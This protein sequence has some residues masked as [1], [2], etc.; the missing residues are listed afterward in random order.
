M[1]QLVFILSLLLL[2]S[3]AHAELTISYAWVRLLPP[4]IKTTAA[5]MD[6]HSDQNDI[7]LSVS[8]SAALMVEMHESVEEEGV[9]SME[10]ISDVI[11]PADQTISLKP[12]GTHLMIMGLVEPLQEGNTLP[13]VLTFERAG[14]KT[15]HATI[16]NR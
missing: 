3:F 5:Y 12:Q 6:I 8:T 7:L 10:R 13:L 2:A 16:E 11:L 4:N 9:M 14:E 15:V 1:R